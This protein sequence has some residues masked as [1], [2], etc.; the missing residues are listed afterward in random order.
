MKLL[1]VESSNLS[2][3][4]Y[5][6]KSQVLVALFKN[7]KAY[8]YKP[9]SPEQHK[10]VMEADSIGSAFNKTIVKAENIGY[11][12]IPPEKFKKAIS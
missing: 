7:G 11:K 1:K 8:A 5:E 3:I 2:H 4:G 12:E 10:A 6:E 9:V